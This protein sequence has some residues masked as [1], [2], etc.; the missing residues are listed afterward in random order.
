MTAEEMTFPKLLK[1]PSN[2]IVC[3]LGFED[4]NC[5]MKIVIIDTKQIRSFKSGQI[6]HFCKPSLYRLYH[7]VVK[8]SNGMKLMNVKKGR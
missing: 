6:M 1:S 3:A 5:T 7:G 8:L 2:M 4:D